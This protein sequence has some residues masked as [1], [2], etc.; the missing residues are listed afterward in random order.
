MNE[1]RVVHAWEG[2][3][4]SGDGAAFQLGCSQASRP[5]S[6]AS[7]VFLKK[8]ST[9]L[10]LAQDPP[11]IKNRVCIDIELDLSDRRGILGDASAYPLVTSPCEKL[12]SFTG[13]GLMLSDGPEGFQV[14]CPAN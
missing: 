8:G 3:S 10:N 12:D 13:L 4:A 5:M 6:D 7:P 14:S 9:S 2:V 1:S 11:C